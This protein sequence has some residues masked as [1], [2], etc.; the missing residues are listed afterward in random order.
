MALL[1]AIPEALKLWV[2]NS[3]YSLGRL[4]GVGR[5]AILKLCV[6]N[7]IVIERCHS[8]I[9]TTKEG[10]YG[11]V[12]RAEH[13]IEGVAAVKFAD[14]T[15]HLTFKRELE[16]YQTLSQHPHPNVCRLLSYT[17]S[18]DTACLI[19]EHAMM[20][21]RSFINQGYMQMCMVPMIAS[22]MAKGLTALHEHQIIHRDLKPNNIL[23]TL[24]LTGP[25][26]QIA[27]FGL[28]RVLGKPQRSS[29]AVISEMTPGVVPHLI[30]SERLIYH[31]LD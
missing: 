17:H 14:V 5:L 2:A 12:Y 20:D 18:K 10:T 19:F 31:C 4:L 27:D 23:V 30:F 28:A 8:I 15:D 22:H 24:Q 1:K 3:G 6:V 7:L 9:L 26:F 29:R 21:L 16:V 13:S 25:V 11:K